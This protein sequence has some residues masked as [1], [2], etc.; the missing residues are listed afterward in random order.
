MNYCYLADGIMMLEMRK[1]NLHILLALLVLT[2]CFTCAWGIRYVGDGSARVRI[3]RGFDYDST[4]F[5][6]DGVSGELIYDAGHNMLKLDTIIAG[7]HVFIETVSTEECS[8]WIVVCNPDDS[9]L[10]RAY[11]LGWC[12][13][14][15]DHDWGNLMKGTD[16]PFRVESLDVENRRVGVRFFN[17][18]TAVLDLHG[19]ICGNY[20]VECHVDQTDVVAD[21]VRISPEEEILVMNNSIS[22]E[23][24]YKGHRI[25]EKTIWPYSFKGIDT[26][27]MYILAPTGKVWFEVENDVLVAS[28]GM[29]MFDTDCGYD[30]EIRVSSDGKVKMMHIVSEQFLAFSDMIYDFKNQYEGERLSNLALTMDFYD[31][32]SSSAQEYALFLAFCLYN[33]DAGAW[34]YAARNLYEMFVRYPEKFDE[35]HMCL[36]VLNDT[37]RKKVKEVMMELLSPELSDR[38]SG[39]I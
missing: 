8:D 24:C 22:M 26:P 2:V 27:E 39:K 29:Y 7:N 14:L 33:T 16:K 20:Y 11:N 3:I 5:L 10:M 19:E 1:K 32:P 18:S 30:I 15:D 17:D 38:I 9:L 4:F 36:R 37:Q 6:V 13:R 28:T 34:E 35:L 12:F 31:E 23:I 25:L 21:T